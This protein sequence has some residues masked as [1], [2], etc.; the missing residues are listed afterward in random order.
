MTRPQPSYP[1]DS[2]LSVSGE[3]AAS[4]SPPEPGSPREV[5]LAMLAYLGIPSPSACSR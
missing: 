4:A 1:M 2:G 3:D 5:H